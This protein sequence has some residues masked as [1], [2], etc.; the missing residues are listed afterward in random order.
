VRQ[1][2][3]QLLSGAEQRQRGCTPDFEAGSKARRAA[4]ASALETARNRIT[5]WRQ[6]HP[7][8]HRPCPPA[9]WILPGRASRRRGASRWCPWAP[10][11]SPTAQHARCALGVAG[12]VCCSLFCGV[13]R[14]LSRVCGRGGREGRRSCPPVQLLRGPT[15]AVVITKRRA[16]C[17]RISSCCVVRRCCRTTMRPRGWSWWWTETTRW[18]RARA[19]LV[20]Y[21]SVCVCV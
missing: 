19:C 5:S 17:W 4:G 7:R 12:F 18:A 20:V 16:C 21:V 3:P 2:P 13:Q 10:R 1:L 6:D 14:H 11:Y 15:R 8:A 9:R